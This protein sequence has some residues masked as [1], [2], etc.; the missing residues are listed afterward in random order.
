MMKSIRQSGDKQ[1]VVLFF[2][3]YAFN[4]IEWEA[5]NS[6]LGYI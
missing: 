6:E 2:K 4:F 1:Q 5:L 3:K